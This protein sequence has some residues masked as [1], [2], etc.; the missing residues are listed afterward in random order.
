MNLF[1][2]EF[3]NIVNNES[4]GSKVLNEQREIEFKRWK[5]DILKLKKQKNDYSVNTNIVHNI[6]DIEYADDGV[7]LIF[8]SNVK[9]NCILCPISYI[10]SCPLIVRNIKIINTEEKDIQLILY[11]TKSYDK[12]N[13]V[14][15]E[16]CNTDE[17]T[18]L[19][20]VDFN[21]INIIDTLFKGVFNTFDDYHKY[22]DI[23]KNKF[24]GVNIWM[25]YETK[26]LQPGVKFQ[27]NKNFIASLL[28][29]DELVDTIIYND[30]VNISYCTFFNNCT[31]SK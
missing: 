22:I 26:I 10:I 13:N 28:R 31:L 17:L 25:H 16:T 4:V 18:L 21:G 15:Y 8:D 6:D 1:D 3:D 5:D 11:T 14:T 9:K 27:N 2:E 20:N 19:N 7:T 29:Y 30:I 24:N 12:D 23:L